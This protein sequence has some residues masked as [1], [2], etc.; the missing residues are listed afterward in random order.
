MSHLRLGA[1]TYRQLLAEYRQ[2]GR[3]RWVDHYANLL[4]TGALTVPEVE[5]CAAYQSSLPL[6]AQLPLGDAGD[7]DE[8]D[9]DDFL[10]MMAD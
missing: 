1:E 2:L 3:T 4:S 6:S 7:N 8:D 10:S 5:A 9:E